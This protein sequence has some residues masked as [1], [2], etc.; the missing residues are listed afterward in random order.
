MFGILFFTRKSLER[1]QGR[2]YLGR[3]IKALYDY[4]RKRER[5]WELVLKRCVGECEVIYSLGLV[6]TF[7]KLYIFRKIYF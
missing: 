7:V 6:V 4:D 3:K 2:S 5:D 1:L